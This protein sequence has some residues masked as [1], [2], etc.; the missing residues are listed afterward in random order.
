MSKQILAVQDLN[1]LASVAG[2]MPENP[3][4]EMAKLVG[5]SGSLKNDTVSK[6]LK[7]FYQ[8]REQDADPEE[9]YSIE[10]VMKG[11]END[12]F[13]TEYAVLDVLSKKD[14]DSLK[15]MLLIWN[16]H[17]KRGELDEGLGQI[18]SFLVHRDWFLD[19][20]KRRGARI[21]VT[22][23]VQKIIDTMTNKDKTLI[24]HLLDK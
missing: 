10:D 14:K 1:Y 2:M 22:P 8:V 21:K 15:P 7:Q 3:L 11:L 18:R 12:N 23:Q 4:A 20:A 13:H 5:P 9:N 16:E 19:F 24:N 17:Q 6:M